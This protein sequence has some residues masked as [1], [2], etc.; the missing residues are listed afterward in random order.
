MICCYRYKGAADVFRSIVA[1]DGIL[2]LWKGWAPNC[3]RAA[4][5]C[6][7]GMYCTFLSFFLVMI[8]VIWES[9]AKDI[10]Q[11]FMLS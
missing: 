10:T 6:L 7:G 1:K 9:F 8:W 4:I 2:G 11:N 5:V 3:Q